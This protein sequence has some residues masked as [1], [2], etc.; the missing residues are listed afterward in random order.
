ME[1]V[2]ETCDQ[3][4]P[5]LGSLKS[6]LNLLC[7][8]WVFNKL[9]LRNS[10]VSPLGKN[11]G[12]CFEGPVFCFKKEMSLEKWKRDH[13]QKNHKVFQASFGIHRISMVIR[14]LQGLM[15]IQEL[16]DLYDTEADCRMTRGEAGCWMLQL[17]QFIWFKMQL[18]WGMN[19]PELEHLKGK[20][21]KDSSSFQVIESL[22]FRYR[23]SLNIWQLVAENDQGWSIM[24]VFCSFLLAMPLCLSDSCSLQPTWISAFLEFQSQRFCPKKC[25]GRSEHTVDG[26][27]PANQLI[28]VEVGSLS[29]Y[30]PL[31]CLQGFIGGCLGFPPSTG[32]SVFL[33]ITV[34]SIFWSFFFMP[35]MIQ[36]FAST[37]FFSDVHMD[38]SE[39]RG[40]PKSSILIGFLIINHPFWGTPIFGNTH[41][42]IMWIVFWLFTIIS[43]S[44]PV[45][46]F[47]WGGW[48]YMICFWSI[49]CTHMY[50]YIYII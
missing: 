23:N 8:W 22:Y 21:Q 4:V 7:C 37:C 40:T 6:P 49:I 24:F 10:M 30:C 28:Y 20:L 47:V 50:I 14:E 38:V 48:G 34:L 32:G 41:M 43:Q 9:S 17:G 15:K 42:L 35:Q 13:Y 27:N 5:I 44:L 3:G 39:N 26:R 45:S 12:P 36:W 31:L 16:L 2:W 46:S 33:F 18:F 19:F 29:H 11:D 1:I 25:V